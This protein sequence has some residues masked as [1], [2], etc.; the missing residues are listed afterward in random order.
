MDDNFETYEGGADYPTTDF[1]H[2]LGIFLLVICLLLILAL[3]MFAAYKW[4][5]HKQ[6]KSIEGDLKDSAVRIFLVI[7]WRIDAYSPL[8]GSG[9][10]KAALELLAEFK[11]RLGDVIDLIAPLNRLIADLDSAL[12]G[13]P[14]SLNCNGS[15]SVS[16]CSCNEGCSGSDNCKDTCGCKTPSASTNTNTNTNTNIHLNQIMGLP[17]ILYTPVHPVVASPTQTHV[18]TPNRLSYSEREYII[19]ELLVEIATYW[20]KDE[21]TTQIIPQIIKAQKQLN[22]SVPLPD[23]LLKKLE[24]AAL[25]SKGTA[26][27]IFN[28][29]SFKLS[30]NASP[31][32]NTQPSPKTKGPDMAAVTFLILIV[33]GL[34]GYYIFSTTGH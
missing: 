31:H 8:S 1:P 10:Q 32:K 7:K 17:Q 22:H 29:V 16:A 9:T 13:K 24:K 23:E 30:S 6:K 26:W 18:S 5:Q 2:D 19:H 28:W 27:V 14:K 3:L 15:C 34:I 11:L 25:A 4:G 33:F 21:A 20:G 12:Q